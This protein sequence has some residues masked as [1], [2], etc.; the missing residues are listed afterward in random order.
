[1]RKLILFGIALAALVSFIAIAPAGAQTATSTSRSVY[2]RG[3]F[4]FWGTVTMYSTSTNQLGLNGFDFTIPRLNFGPNVRG[5]NG[6]AVGDRVKVDGEVMN[7]VPV[8]TRI[9]IVGK[10]ATFNRVRLQTGT[11]TTTAATSTIPLSQ[12]FL[13]SL[14]A[15]L[16]NIQNRLQQLMSMIATST[17][18]TTSTSGTTATSTA[19]TT[20]TST[21]AT[22]TTPTAGTGGGGY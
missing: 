4:Q 14:Q 8:I 20:A 13:Q 11:A 22:T 5:L 2:D 19:T 21:G 16:R 7:N 18:A 3:V 17:T 9:Q 6:I 12:S 1:M 10:T 15:Q